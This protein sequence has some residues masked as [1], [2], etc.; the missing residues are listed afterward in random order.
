MTK[1][2][3][4]VEMTAVSNDRPGEG[5]F[6][7]PRSP[8]PASTVTGTVHS[9]LASA[10]PALGMTGAAD[11]L[12]KAADGLAT[13]GCRSRAALSD[14]LEGVAGRPL[15]EDELEVAYEAFMDHLSSAR[16]ANEGL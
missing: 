2:D 4:V 10:L 12:H 14:C 9:A 5:L 7:T 1:T 6:F 16:L 8:H 15:R 13:R 3:D 11:V